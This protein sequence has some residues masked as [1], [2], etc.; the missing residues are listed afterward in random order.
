[1]AVETDPSVQDIQRECRLARDSRQ[2]TPCGPAHQ[3]KLPEPVLCVDV[4]HREEARFWRTR[5]D[6]GSPEIVSY[7]DCRPGKP[8]QPDQPTT[9]R[10]QAEEIADAQHRTQTHHPSEV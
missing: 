7:H 2:F 3:L 1:M 4:P 9:L 5:P 8:L 10:P 6:A